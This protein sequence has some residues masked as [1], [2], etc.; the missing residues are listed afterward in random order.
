MAVHWLSGVRTVAPLL[1]QRQQETPPLPAI[2]RGGW[3]PEDRIGPPGGGYATLTVVFR[4]WRGKLKVKS[5]SERNWAWLVGELAG[6]PVEA[7]AEVDQLD[8]DGRHGDGGGVELRV[9][10]ADDEPDWVQLTGHGISR[11]DG[12]PTEAE[13]LG[14]WISVLTEATAFAEPTFAVIGESPSIG[15]TRLDVALGRSA[16]ESI[17]RAREVLRGFSWL[18]LC[19]AGLAN[20]LGG[21]DA[22]RGTG[23]F[24]KVTALPGGAVVL[25][26]TDSIV[27]YGPAETYRVYWALARVLPKGVPPHMQGRD[28]R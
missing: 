24:A 17:A 7:A 18:T 22:L 25:Q 5:Y 19:P 28:P 9:Q 3:V 11:L 12:D 20:K 23:A 16:E 26:A 27:D 10:T 1:W 13:F 14:R 4:P 21:P 6:R 15:R 8:E 2:M